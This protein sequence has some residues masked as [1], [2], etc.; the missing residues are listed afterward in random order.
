MSSTPF[1]ILGSSDGFVKGLV[2]VPNTQKRPKKRMTTPSPNKIAN[3]ALPRSSMFL[4]DTIE[5][6][7]IF[8]IY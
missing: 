8:Q 7:I 3:Y 5:N 6:K 2:P 1:L 4:L